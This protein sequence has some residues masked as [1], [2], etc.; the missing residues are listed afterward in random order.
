LLE[1]E[2]YEKRS[3]AVEAWKKMIIPSVFT[4]R[5]GKFSKRFTR[6]NSYI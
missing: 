5:S 1:E 6:R 2:S 3:A 4:D